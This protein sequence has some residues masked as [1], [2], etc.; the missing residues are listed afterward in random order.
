MSSFAKEGS[1][2][3]NPFV[4]AYNFGPSLEANRSVRHLVEEALR[5]WPDIG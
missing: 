4:G 2:C 1:E 3:L 5:Y